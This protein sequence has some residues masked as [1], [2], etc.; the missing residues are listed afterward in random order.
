VAVRDQ[1]ATVSAGSPP[2]KGFDLVLMAAKSAI[3]SESDQS[4]SF[5]SVGRVIE[6][7]A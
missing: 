7:L 6:R 2:F 3:S 4:S 5:V 1:Q